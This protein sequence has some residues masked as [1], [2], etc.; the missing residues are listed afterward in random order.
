MNC[1]SMYCAHE[2]HICIQTGKRKKK[3][4]IKKKSQINFFKYRKIPKF[5]SKK[6][7]FFGLRMLGRSDG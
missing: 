2:A 3:N 1:R 6:N 5:K 4:D 7:F